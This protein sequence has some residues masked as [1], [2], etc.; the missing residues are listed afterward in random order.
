[1]NAFTEISTIGK[2]FA[3]EFANLVGSGT[4]ASQTLTASGNL[5]AGN[6]ITVS[7]TDPMTLAVWS[8]VY[9]AAAT[10]TTEGQFLIGADAPATW[11]NFVKAVEA[12]SGTYNSTHLCLIKNPLVRG[13][14]TT[15]SLVCTLAAR[16]A[17][18]P[19]GGNTIALAK[20]AA[21][22]TL[23][24]ATLAGGISPWLA[25]LKAVLDLL[26]CPIPT[27]GDMTVGMTIGGSSTGITYDSYNLGSWQKVGNHYEVNGFCSIT[28]KG[29]LTGAVVLTGFPQAG[30]RTGGRVFNVSASAGG[31]N[32]VTGNLT[33]TIATGTTVLTLSLVSNS[34]LTALDAANIKDGCRIS[35]SGVYD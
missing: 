25:K 15:A 29:G 28:S 7:F 23:G 30:A 16:T 14:H 22:V 12:D 35:F 11:D 19:Q 10:L 1:M 32:S 9:T 5:S 17:N 13:T 26:F 20:S 4:P 31:M 18:G 24:G 21:N 27:V 3:E 33:G 6:T 8:K 2:Q 34:V